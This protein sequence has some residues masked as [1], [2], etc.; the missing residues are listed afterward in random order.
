[1]KGFLR[2]CVYGAA[3]T[4]GSMGVSKGIEVLSDPYK[5]TKIKNRFYKIKDAIFNK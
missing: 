3:I 4:L 5:R 1:M 2:C